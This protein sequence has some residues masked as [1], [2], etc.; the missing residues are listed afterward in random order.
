M[1]SWAIC[2]SCV[3]SPVAVVIC[4]DSIVLGQQFQ[5]PEV[6][7]DVGHEAMI[8][9][10]SLLAFVFTSEVE[11]ADLEWLSVHLNGGVLRHVLIFCESDTLQDFSFKSF[12]FDRPVLNALR[13]RCA[14]HILQIIN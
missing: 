2:C 1:A 11:R 13:C 6:T 8:Q 14:A 4:H 10:H 5:E 12:T 3:E 7:D 9:N